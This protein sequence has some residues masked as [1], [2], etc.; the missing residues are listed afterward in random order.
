MEQSREV[1]TR[2]LIRS[3]ICE[4]FRLGPVVNQLDRVLS[5]HRLNIHHRAT[6]HVTL[7]DLC[8]A[9][10]ASHSGPRMS[11]PIIAVYSYIGLNGSLS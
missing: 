3:T 4:F 7:S 1:G 8:I 2:K 10:I 11:Q 5:S 9:E 6:S